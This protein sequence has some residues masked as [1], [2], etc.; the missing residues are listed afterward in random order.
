MLKPNETQAE[1]QEERTL[2]HA[3]IVGHVIAPTICEKDA[4]R[5]FS[6]W[7]YESE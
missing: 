4:R 7:E 6:L 3:A 2:E 5:H 1:T